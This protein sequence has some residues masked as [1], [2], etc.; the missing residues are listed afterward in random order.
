MVAIAVPLRIAELEA[1]PPDQFWPRRRE[2][3]A[4]AEEEGGFSEAVLFRVKGE[5]ARA[6]NA[7]ARLI[8]AMAFTPGGITIFDQHFAAVPPGMRKES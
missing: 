5:S 8:A 6:F 4:R 2:W 3:L 1:L 7:L